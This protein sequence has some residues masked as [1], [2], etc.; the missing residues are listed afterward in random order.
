MRKISNGKSNEFC[1]QTLFLYGTY[2][3]DK[4]PNFG[5]FCWFSYTWHSELGVMACIGGDKLT[6]D[7]IR[8]NKVFSANLVNKP[9]L[10]LADYY[11]NKNGYETDKMNIVPDYTNGDT[12][13]VPII[14]NSP[15]NIELEAIQEVHLDGS[16]VFICK[17]HNTMV[18][19]NLMDDTLNIEE[20]IQQLQ[21]VFTTC[22]TYFSQ[23]CTNVGHWGQPMKDIAVKKEK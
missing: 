9:L 15:V 14:K 22:Q 16:D 18:D 3:E 21:P 8:K 6:K 10:K 11:G 20:K 2:K 17:I 23:E 19:E 13:N 1:P 7:L 5:L 12:L 4:T